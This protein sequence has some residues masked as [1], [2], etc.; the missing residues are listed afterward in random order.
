MKGNVEAGVWKLKIDTLKKPD[1][2][3]LFRLDFI[4]ET[5]QAPE[6]PNSTAMKING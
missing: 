6:K 5:E 4:W 2:K 1:G 3:T